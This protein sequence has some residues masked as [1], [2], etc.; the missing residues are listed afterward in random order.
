MRVH[1]VC[2][3]GIYWHSYFLIFFCFFEC[4]SEWVSRRAYVEYIGTRIFLY[5]FV[6]V[7]VWVSEWVGVRTWNILALVFSYIFFCFREWVIEWVC[8]R[9][10]TKT[11]KYKKI[12]VPIYSMHADPP[13]HSLKNFQKQK[14]IR[15][16]EWQYIP[17]TRARTHA[18][19]LTKT[20]K[21]KKIRVP[22]YSD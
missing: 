16:Y 2:K 3:I 5:F 19:S 8:V 6:F 1:P 13:T 10:L 21:Y 4:L 12:R 9:A 18:Y 7:S 20:K 22:I 11:N 15:K 17:C 14:N